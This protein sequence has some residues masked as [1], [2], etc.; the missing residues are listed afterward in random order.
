M[1]SPTMLIG[2]GAFGFRVFRSLLAWSAAGGH[3]E[4]EFVSVADS[5][6]TPR[7]LRN[8]S[9]LWLADD[10]GAV[11]QAF[12]VE[13]EG[14][15]DTPMLRDFRDEILCC[16]RDDFLQ[17]AES[18]ARRLLKRG[19]REQVGLDVVVLAEP[20]E[21]GVFG[22]LSPR[23]VALF[24]KLGTFPQFTWQGQGAH[25]LQAIQIL[26]LG[27]YWSAP[28]SDLRA[29]LLRYATHWEARYQSRKAS[30]ARTF[31]IGEDSDVHKSSPQQRIDEVVLFLEF[32]LFSGHRREVLKRA[33]ARDRDDEGPLATMSIRL[34]EWNSGL[35]RRSAAARFGAGWM[36][37]LDKAAIDDP[38]ELISWG[39]ELVKE[40]N[41]DQGSAVVSEV[42]VVVGHALALPMDGPNWPDEVD[43]LIVGWR[44]AER[45]VEASP[46]LSGD[47]RNLT[48]VS[49]LLQ[50]RITEDLRSDVEPI[51]LRPMLQRVEGLA[52]AISTALERST[53]RREDGP[54]RE[55]L[56]SLHRVYR[57]FLSGQVEPNGLIVWWPLYAA[58]LAAGMIPPIQEA[59]H[60]VPSPPTTSSGAWDRALL[61]LSDAA[62]TLSA[63]HWS[64]AFA[65]LLCCALCLGLGQ[66]AVLPRL[67]RARTFWEH[68]SRGR[69]GWIVTRM[70]SPALGRRGSAAGE[71]FPV[72]PDT[73]ELLDAAQRFATPLGRRLDEVRWLRG[74]L[75]SF[76]R[77]RGLLGN[78]A[79]S[80]VADPWSSSVRKFGGDADEYV[81][82]T[83]KHPTTPDHFKDA[84]RQLTV[85]GDW[86]AP[87]VDRF[88]RPLEFLNLVARSWKGDAGTDSDGGPESEARTVAEFL[89]ANLTA[90][91]PFFLKDDAAFSP[92][93]HVVLHSS[94]HRNRTVQDALERAKISGR[95]VTEAPSRDRSWVLSIRVGLPLAVIGDRSRDGGAE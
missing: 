61:A 62:H 16:G 46:E 10:L 65:G 12:D 78:D 81:R 3:V 20:T 38:D 84:Q 6:A 5:S 34:F 8:L 17:R 95:L 14:A 27:R 9:M 39:Q 74:Q 89:R 87:Y 64:S 25:R 15:L 82:L 1:S 42:P 68:R 94:L 59:L 13:R 33:F 28:D 4:W 91:S 47:E 90:D 30:F 66:T 36:G 54:G 35:I 40:R 67:A 83:Q 75:H 22:N 31:L 88:L 32:Q 76:L 50:R 11:G 56:R 19:D 41:P 55:E 37:Y 60:G 2:Y 77:Q 45:D 52:K 21:S 69:L 92:T 80:N 79:S 86:H 72:T 57:G 48:P 70:A 51:A 53:H 73:I 71:R 29:S 93:F 23:L 43:D 24:D 63:P 58:V 26:D 85:F 44:L 49:D 7:R 18:E